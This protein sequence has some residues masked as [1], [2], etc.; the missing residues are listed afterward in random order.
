MGQY[1]TEVWGIYQAPDLKV[2]AWGICKFVILYTQCA[3][4]CRTCPRCV[5]QPNYEMSSKSI[6][7]KSKQTNKHI[8]TTTTTTTNLNVNCIRNYLV[9]PSGFL[10]YFI[11]DLDRKLDKSTASVLYLVSCTFEIVVQVEGKKNFRHSV[12]W[13]AYFL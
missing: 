1:L 10:K 8:P 11:T 5:L 9:K 13:W 2:P 7:R 4:F 3:L 12:L 6:N